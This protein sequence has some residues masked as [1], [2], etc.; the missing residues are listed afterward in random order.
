MAIFAPLLASTPEASLPECCRAHGKHHCI[1]T[2]GGAGQKS[3]T[4]REQCSSFPK[5]ALKGVLTYSTPAHRET[6][7]IAL[8]DHPAAVPRTE[9]RYRESLD[10][11]RQ[12][13]GPPST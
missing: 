8:V 4:L 5:A 2:D 6:T 12:N 9:A 1:M 13:R 10:R 3:P 7:S 11:S